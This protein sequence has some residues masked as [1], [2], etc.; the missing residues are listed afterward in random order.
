M[1]D[2][3]HTPDILE[4]LRNTPNWLR[5]SY[6]HWKD[7][8]R[9]YDR[10]PF[11]AAEEIERLREVMQQARDALAQVTTSETFYR[12]PRGD[13]AGPAIDALDAAIGAKEDQRG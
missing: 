8:T 4:R 3:N 13:N 6:G 9:E 7:C 11:E 5:E 12:D 10:A 2:A 1:A